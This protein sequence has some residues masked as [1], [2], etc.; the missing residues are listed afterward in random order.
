MS[1]INL[2]DCTIIVHEVRCEGYNTPGN[3]PQRTLVLC[4]APGGQSVDKNGFVSLFQ[5]TG[6][7]HP[8]APSVAVPCGAH[9]SRP[10]S[11]ARRVWRVVSA[12]LRA[13]GNRGPQAIAPGAGSFRIQF[14]INVSTGAICLRPA[15]ADRPR[16]PTI[17]TSSSACSARSGSEVP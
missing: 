15:P 4:P 9:H 2:F 14:D 12:A 6:P 17:R 3:C 13:N 1:V 10:D 8:V 5:L 7:R 16:L 11:A